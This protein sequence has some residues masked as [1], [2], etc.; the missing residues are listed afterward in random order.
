MD[1]ISLL[2]ANKQRIK[3]SGKSIREDIEKLIDGNSFVEFATFSY[4]NDAFFNTEAAGEG[5]VTGFATIDGNPF[6]IVAQNPAVL[7][8][9][10]SKANCEKIISCLD[11]ALKASVP[12]IYLLSTK[13]VRIGEG[14]TVLEGLAALLKKASELKLCVSQYL[15]VDG[16]VYGQIALLAGLCDFT[17]FLGNKSVLAVNSPLV[18]S[19][20][21]NKNIAAAEVGGAKAYKKANIVSFIVDGMEEVRQ[22]VVKLNNLILSETEDCQD[23]NSPIPQLDKQCKTDDIFKIF[24]KSATVEIG[25]EFCPEIRCVLTRIGGIAVAAAVFESGEGVYLTA[26][27]M[28][29]IKTFCDFAASYDIPFITFVNALGV[30][31]GLEV[32]DSPVIGQISDYI[33]SLGNSNAKISVIYGN[34]IGLGYTLFASK[35]IGFDYVY[36]FAT[37]KVALFSDVQGAEI[38]F[39]NADE[40]KL[41]EKYSAERSD[42]VNAAKGGYID[43]IIQ[44]SLVRQYLIA[45]LQMLLK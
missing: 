23:L 16:E 13:G 3:Q 5:V 43:N 21:S 6:Y 41:V 10:V 45:S 31:C 9:G 38:E 11:K 36:A 7:S 19:A 25:A 2:K 28:D 40:D 18:I 33:G 27:N 37:A 4:S 34:A 24:D 8:G 32:N 20:K 39:G 42:P 29:K 35:S 26:E 22:T 17:F 30:K 12:V 14:V 15:V 1:K 44:P